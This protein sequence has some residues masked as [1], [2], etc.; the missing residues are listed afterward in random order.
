MD[1]GA[2]AIDWEHR[3]DKEPEDENKAKGFGLAINMQGS[4]IPLVD[5]GRSEVKAERGRLL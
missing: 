1:L 2:E 3:D 5:L 4:G